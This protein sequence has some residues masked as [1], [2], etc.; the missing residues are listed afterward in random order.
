VTDFT[1]AD[2]PVSAEAYNEL[3]ETTSRNHNLLV[4]IVCVLEGHDDI[5]AVS[6]DDFNKIVYR[7]EKLQRELREARNLIRLRNP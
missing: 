7:I 3:L 5:Q 1:F 6:E 4:Q 2:R